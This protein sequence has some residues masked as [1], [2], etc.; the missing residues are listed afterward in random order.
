MKLAF[1]G[2]GTIAR[3]IWE[4][5]TGKMP[6]TATYV[7]FYDPG[8]SASDPALRKY[9]IKKFETLDDLLKEEISILVEAANLHVARK[10]VP[11]ILEK[12]IDVLS[13][14]VGAYLGK[15]TFVKIKDIV[16]KKGA[17]RLYLPSGS[18]P[19]VDVIAAASL[20]QIDFVELLTRKPPKALAGAKGFDYEEK[21]LG[22]LEE[23]VVVF[24]GN[25][26][27]AIHLFPK[28]I[29]IA[30]TLSLAGVGPEKTQVKIVADPN[31]KY[32]THRITIKG[33][34]GTLSSEIECKPSSN[35][36]TAIMAALSATSLL[37]KMDSRIR[38]GS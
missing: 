25:A 27:E 2:F 10:T 29:N 19:S 12:G 3:I 37:L 33:D 5:L 13:L 30:A 35:P 16:S 32:N 36:K 18:L 7:G 22:Q 11:T 17:G 34:F 14:S 6:N 26:E 9:S 24:S 15:A 4:E 28:N 21:S 38:I 31:I 8:V 23:P 20:R 1:L